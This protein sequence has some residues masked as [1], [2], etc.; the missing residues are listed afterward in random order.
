MH[1]WPYHSQNNGPSVTVLCLPLLLSP[2]PGPHSVLPKHKSLSIIN[3]PLPSCL[4]ALPR[5]VT[6]CETHP[7]LPLHLATNCSFFRCQVFLSR[8]SLVSHLGQMPV[9]LYYKWLPSPH[10][11]NLLEGGH[12]SASLTGVLCGLALHLAHSRYSLN[13]C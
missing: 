3:R 10:F 4:W 2:P 13:I 5:L 9:P 8:E 6:L 11:Y 1:Q 7:F 12:A